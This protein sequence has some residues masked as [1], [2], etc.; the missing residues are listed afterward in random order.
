[1][2][3]GVLDGEVNRCIGAIFDLHKGITLEGPNQPGWI[4]GDT[5][6]VR[7]KPDIPYLFFPPLLFKLNHITE[8]CLRCLPRRPSLYRICTTSKT[9]SDIHVYIT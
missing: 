4:F 3:F 8:K 6:L 5:F 9:W 7:L 2:N 1:M